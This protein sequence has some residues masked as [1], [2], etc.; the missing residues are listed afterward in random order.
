MYSKLK[1]NTFITGLRTCCDILSSLVGVT[2]DVLL[3]NITEKNN[4][5]KTLTFIYYLFKI[6]IN[7]LKWNI[8]TILTTLIKYLQLH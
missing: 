8:F 2:N 7:I 1:N 3:R 5:E 6:Y 4:I